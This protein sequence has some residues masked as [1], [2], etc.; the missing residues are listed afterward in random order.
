MAMATIRPKTNSRPLQTRHNTGTS[1]ISDLLIGLGWDPLDETDS[2]HPF[3][4]DVM[5][6]MLDA[7]DRVVHQGAI[8]Y[9][10]PISLDGACYVGRD[11]LDGEGPGEDEVGGI[12]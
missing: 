6:F 8:H 9:G 12:C 4:G 7:E 1:S 5:L 2:G 10:Q 3:D 11:N